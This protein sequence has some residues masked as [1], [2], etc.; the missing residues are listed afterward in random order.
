MKYLKLFKSFPTNENSQSVT[1]SDEDK[2]YIENAIKSL[3]NRSWPIC[4]KAEWLLLIRQA[5]S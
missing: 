3:K 4:W 5:N 2:R 1:F